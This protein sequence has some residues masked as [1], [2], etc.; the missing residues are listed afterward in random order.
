MVEDFDLHELASADKVAGDLNIRFARSG[1]ARG[2]VVRQDDGGRLIANCFGED[3][4]RMNQEG[5]QTALRDEANP[6]QTPT[7]IEQDGL[8]PD[9]AFGF[10]R[11]CK[12]IQLAKSKAAGAC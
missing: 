1:I 8:N 11:S 7:S 5:I 3:F 10:A 9:F 4:T 2:M 6:K 12:S